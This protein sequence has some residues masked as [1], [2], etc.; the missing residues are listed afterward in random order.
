VSNDRTDRLQAALYRI[1]ETASSA[2]DMQGF[3][4]DIHRIVGELMYADN[5]YIVLYDE[6]RQSLNWAYFVDGSG[7]TAPD[8]NVREPIGTGEARGL[9]AY[10]LREGEP[11]FVTFDDIQQMATAG[12]IQMLGLPSVDWLGV[13]LR[14]D[15]KTVGAMVV[16][17]YREDVHHT[18]QD[19]EVLAFV[20]THVGSALSRARAIE[21]TRQR[22]AELALVNDVQRGLAEKLDMQAMY[23]LV[24]DRI[25][26]I[27]DAQ[28]VD[29]GILDTA[30]NLVHFAYTIERGVRFHD[31]PI[32]LVGFRRV[33]IETLEPVAINED[34]ERLSA[35]AGQPYVISGEPPK[36]AVFVPLAVG[37]R[38]TGVISLQ[39]LDRENAFSESDIRLLTTLASSLSVALEN[40]RLFEETRARNAELALINL[41]QRGLVENLNSQAMYDLVGDRL[42]DIFDAQIVDIGVLD[43]DGRVFH[44][45]YT[46]ERGELFP[47]KPMEVLGFRKHVIETK[48]PLLIHERFE[49]RA[50]E[51]GNPIVHQGAQAK[52]VLFVPLVVGSEATG[53]ILL[54]NLDREQAFTDAD[55]RL[56]STL[57]SSLSVA[58]EN[59]RLFEETR[60]RNAELALINDIQRGLAQNL[61]M[62]AMYNLVGDRIR[63]IFDAQVVDIGILDPNDGLM[64]FPYSIERGERFPDE[65]IRPDEGL[66]AV[67]LERKEPILVKRPEDAAAIASMVLLGTGEPAK[68]ALFVPLVV[69]GVAMTDLPAEPGPRICLRRSG[70]ALARHAGRKPERRS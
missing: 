29:I 8:P 36:S 2:Q 3:Y 22:S 53:V 62:D 51:F 68:S 31:E 44:F 63:E 58:L 6:D 39:N 38:A 60:Q 23:D 30:T 49:E 19:K 25:Q 45:P 55:V 48:Q 61:D 13:P 9:T 21:E 12:T 70:C 4:A 59:A 52:S 26:E 24:G 7:D 65:P 50:A 15:G 5:F 37:G 1:A 64:H 42:H 67:A 14:A 11:L 17:S 43:A 47:D 16:Q 40:A 46:I 20:A 66:T 69:G 35:A 27:F 34:I 33:A 18:E 54:G 57:A 56:L 32:Q 10:V 28:V 41:V